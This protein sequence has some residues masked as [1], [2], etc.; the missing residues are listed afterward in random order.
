MISKET[1]AALAKDFG[2]LVVYKEDDDLEW[3]IYVTF[4]ARVNI[5]E[6]LLKGL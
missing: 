6:P 1:V 5:Q 3:S 4:L 2:R